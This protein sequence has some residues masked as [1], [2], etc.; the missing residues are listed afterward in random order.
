MMGDEN[1]EQRITARL[2]ELEVARAIDSGRPPCAVAADPRQL[3][4]RR[5]VPVGDVDRPLGGRPGFVAEAEPGEQPM[6]EAAAR[7]GSQRTGRD[8]VR[9]LACQRGVHLGVESG[10]L[11][12]RA[13]A[14][15]RKPE[16]R[17]GNPG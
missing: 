3:R 13:A 16:R 10:E 4:V 17:V 5:L 8:D 6:A 14:G 9:A 15:D 11:E 2:G 7:Q 1:L 12:D